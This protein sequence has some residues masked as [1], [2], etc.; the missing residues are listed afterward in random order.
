M[1]VLCELPGLYAGRVYQTLHKYQLQGGPRLAE[2][3]ARSGAGCS[4]RDA[5]PV[6]PPATSWRASARTEPQHHNRLSSTEAP[7]VGPGARRC[8]WNRSIDHRD[9]GSQRVIP[10]PVASTSPGGPTRDLLS[11]GWAQEPTFNKPP[12][13]CRH[14][15]RFVATLER[16][17]LPTR[18]THLCSP[19]QAQVYQVLFQGLHL[20]ELTPSSTTR[21]R[22]YYQ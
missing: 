9:I 16:C 13:G 21:Q 20:P 6:R 8:S 14:L 4:G 18:D 5:E 15:L 10:E 22:S 1:K 19:V 11:G 12:R 17:C 3:L 7:S 2:R